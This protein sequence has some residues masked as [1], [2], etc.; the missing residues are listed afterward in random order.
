[1]N[2]ARSIE[3]DLDSARIFASNANLTADTHLKK[4]WIAWRDLHYNR[5]GAAHMEG[6]HYPPPLCEYENCDNPAAD[7]DTLCAAH[8][9]WNAQQMEIEVELAHAQRYREQANDAHKRGN[10][11]EAELYNRRAKDAQNTA[12]ALQERAVARLDACV[13][14]QIDA[15][16]EAQEAITERTLD[17]PGGWESG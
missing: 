12:A 15:H 14:Q 4:E 10:Q 5:A 8:Q 7:G 9:Q 13:E 2:I 3:I 16:I 6:E 17:A 1:M 11:L